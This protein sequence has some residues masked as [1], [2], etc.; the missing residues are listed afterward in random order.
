LH[1]WKEWGDWLISLGY[2]A[3]NPARDFEDFIFFEQLILD[4]P[5]PTA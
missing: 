1:I 3:G 4:R 5:I 2:R